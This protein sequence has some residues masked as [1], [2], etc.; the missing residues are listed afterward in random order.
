MCPNSS[1]TR[2]WIGWRTILV[3][4][5]V[6]LVLGLTVGVVVF[7]LHSSS[8]DDRE[9]SVAIATTALSDA[10]S[11]V[12]L[13]TNSFIDANL[14]L[15]RANRLPCSNYFSDVYEVQRDISA[16]ECVSKIK[17]ADSEFETARIELLEAKR[18]L[19]LARSTA[20]R[21][22]AELT[23]AR[24]YSLIVAGI[25]TG[26]AAIVGFGLTLLAA[27]GLARVRVETI[28]MFIGSAIAIIVGSLTGLIV[29]LLRYV[30]PGSAGQSCQLQTA[31][32]QST[33]CTADAITQGVVA[34]L[35]VAV[36]GL[37]VSLGTVVVLRKRQAD[38]TSNALSDP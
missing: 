29:G 36:F 24:S 7:S 25:L 2:A 17:A 22:K 19:E 27:W 8:L 1:A 3:A 11:Q 10:K 34:G 20:V 14:A 13:K 23:S 32:R 37:V 5:G 9:G 15:T 6:A 12:D 38:M 33:N 26:A 31:L 18:D 30:S 4:L 16:G 35:L 28:R 21:S